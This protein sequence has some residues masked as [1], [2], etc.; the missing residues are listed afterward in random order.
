MLDEFLLSESPIMG[1]IWAVVI[2]YITLFGLIIGGG[3]WI[4]GKGKA[5]IWYY[6]FMIFGVAL[7]IQELTRYPIIDTVI[8]AVTG[9][10]NR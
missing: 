4:K 10:F 3:L 1:A 9:L 2:S 8:N 7:L 6:A 5:H